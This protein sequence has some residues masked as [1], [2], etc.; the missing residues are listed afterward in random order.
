MSPTSSEDKVF[1]GGKQ[2]RQGFYFCPRTKKSFFS[3]AE[4][5][6][7]EGRARILFPTQETKAEKLS[8]L[9]S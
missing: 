5:E 3:F 1:I 6:L 4:G 2:A 9:H 7:G 8:V